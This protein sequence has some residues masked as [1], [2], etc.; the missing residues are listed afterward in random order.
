MDRE[1]RCGELT[2]TRDDQRQ[3]V[4]SYLG[5]MEVGCV[6]CQVRYRGTCQQCQL[7]WCTLCQQNREE[8]DVCGIPLMLTADREASGAK[9]STQRPAKRPRDTEVM[10]VNM[11]RLG[12]SFVERVTDVRRRVTVDGKVTAPGESMEFL[13]L[14]QGWQSEARRERRERL[15]KLNDIGLRMALE[16]A[17][18]KDVFF[19][20]E[21]H[22]AEEKPMLA[23]DDGWWYQVRSV[24]WCRTCGKCKVRKERG[25]F[26]HEEWGKRRPAICIACDGTKGVTRVSSEKTKRIHSRVKH[27][28]NPPARRP[29]AAQGRGV[30]IKDVTSGSE[31]DE[32]EEVEWGKCMYGVRMTPA[33]PWYVGRGDDKCG[34][35]VVYSI[36]D[37][38]ELLSVQP[39]EMKRWLT[40]SQMGWALTREENELVN[41]K[42][43]RE[44]K[45]VARQLAPMISKFIRAQWE[46]EGM[47][48]VNDERR[49][50]LEEAVEL[51]Q[52]WGIWE[53]EEESTHEHHNWIRQPSQSGNDMRHH[54]EVH[55][56]HREQVWESP[57][58]SLI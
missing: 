7:R 2:G 9:T 24:I 18:V 25:G 26:T 45:P 23:D 5:A 10:T 22:F 37:I 33:H 52:I 8:C 27:T 29:R 6:G 21:V 51:D 38:R 14:I 3:L 40:T 41:E 12:E 55:A 58:A 32:V 4:V 34:G 28:S 49:Q 13:A 43:E 44:G 39:G 11:H 54:I 19:I 31:D 48:N 50:L 17:T 46:S 30:A 15:L 57:S 56:S 20:P 1:R 35:E 36:K 53:G 42:D 47:E 16:H